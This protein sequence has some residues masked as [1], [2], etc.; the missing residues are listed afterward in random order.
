[1][2]EEPSAFIVAGAFVVGMPLARRPLV[3]VSAHLCDLQAGCRR[4]RCEARLN[5]HPR[6][7]PMVNKELDEALPVDQDNRAPPLLSEPTRCRI[8]TARRDEHELLEIT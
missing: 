2:R 7:E 6:G 3:V 8:E 4:D 5:R 1:M